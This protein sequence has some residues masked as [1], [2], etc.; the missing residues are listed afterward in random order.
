M[1]RPIIYVVKPINSKN[2]R[3]VACVDWSTTTREIYLL[4]KKRWHKIIQDVTPSAAISSYRYTCVVG[5]ALLSASTARPRG[6]NVCDARRGFFITRPMP[7]GTDAASRFMELPVAEGN[8]LSWLT[9]LD[10]FTSVSEPLFGL[11]PK[12]HM[13]RVF[14]NKLRCHTETL[15][16]LILLYFLEIFLCSKNPL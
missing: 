7:D 16:H 2:H 10:A 13:S 1:V 15:E 9:E 6:V 12:N 4:H 8:F 3:E 5:D 14:N 11:E